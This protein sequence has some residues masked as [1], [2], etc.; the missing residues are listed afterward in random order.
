MLDEM[1]AYRD[2]R[3]DTWQESDRGEAFNERIDALESI[4]GELDE[5]PGT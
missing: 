2:E 4:I 1:K 5:L 3:S